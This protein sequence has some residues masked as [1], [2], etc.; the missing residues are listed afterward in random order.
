MGE[1][2]DP[3][4]SEECYTVIVGLWDGGVVFELVACLEVREVVR[5]VEVF[6]D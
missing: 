2:V 6:E 4:V 1:C 3:G 5:F